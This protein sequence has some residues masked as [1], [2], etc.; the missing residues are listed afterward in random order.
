M[1]KNNQPRE[2]NDVGR[3]AQPSLKP[4][5]K[6]CEGIVLKQLP[7]KVSFPLDLNRLPNK[8]RERERETLKL[9][10][11]INRIIWWIQVPNVH[12][13]DVEV[14]DFRMS[15]SSSTYI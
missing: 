11:R 13:K 7:S 5:V 12:E 9:M 4:S 14:T 10:L 6:C 15:K 8:Q 2:F 1:P 3:V